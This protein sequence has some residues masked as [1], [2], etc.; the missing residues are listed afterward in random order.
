MKRLLLFLIIFLISITRTDIYA[1][2][3]AEYVPP[4]GAR[5]LA[6]VVGNDTILLA[7]LHDIWVFP[8]KAFK[9]KE[10]ERFFWR[11]VRDV[12]VALPYAKLV[13]NELSKINY[14][15]VDL[16]SDSERKKYLKQF[17]KEVFK[18]YEADLKKLSIN[19]GRL[20]MKLID[21]ECNQ[22]TFELIRSYKG[23]VSAYFWQG[24]ALVF[25]SNLKTGY[26]A[27]DKDKIIEKVILLVEAH[28]L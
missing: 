14:K 9:N 20:L 11:T 7:Y 26:D 24:L 21:R 22:S 3:K 1:Q 15:L 8:R 25:G 13:A 6:Q 18:K 5:L 16:K 2:S 23:T 17:E 28:Q 10:Q 4:G 12:K 27:S 19:Q